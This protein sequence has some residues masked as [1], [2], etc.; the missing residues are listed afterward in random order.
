MSLTEL[1]ATADGYNLI[2]FRRRWNLSTNFIWCPP[3]SCEETRSAP[4][5]QASQFLSQLSFFSRGRSPNVLNHSLYEI[6]AIPVALLWTF[7]SSPVP[8]IKWWKGKSQNYTQYSE[9]YNNLV[10]APNIF[11]WAFSIISSIS[12]AFFKCLLS[13]GLTFSAQSLYWCFASWWFSKA[14]ILALKKHRA[15]HVDKAP[16]DFLGNFCKLQHYLLHQEASVPYEKDT[17]ESKIDKL[18]PLEH[19]AILGS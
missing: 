13:L 3:N 18:L 1:L 14:A 16:H 7:S 2:L 4:T 17:R 11:C 19:W 10:M 15:S 12:F 5:L 9:V 8:C 6:L